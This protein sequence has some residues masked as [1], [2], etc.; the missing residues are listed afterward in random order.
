MKF[1]AVI[2][3]GGVSS[4]FLGVFKP[5]LI[6][7]D[8]PILAWIVD[9]LSP[10]SGEVIVVVR[11]EKQENAILRAIDGVKVVRDEVSIQA[12]I[13]GALAGARASRS[14]LI[15]IVAG[16]Q[17]FV[18]SE[19]A[20]KIVAK[21]KNYEACVPK[22]PNGYIEPLTAAYAREKFIKVAENLIKRGHLKSSAPLKYLKTLYIDV[23]QL[24]SHPEK[25][26][27]NINTIDD[28]IKAL[29]WAKEI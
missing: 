21:C 24:H 1:D 26:L 14:D 18:T 5:L 2:L 12:P 8:K 6:L 15:F 22:W 3:A 11:D 28:Y 25:I 20:A 29:K 16:D 9:N 23:Y 4:R 13:V 19:V 7:G 27:H 10:V 17:P